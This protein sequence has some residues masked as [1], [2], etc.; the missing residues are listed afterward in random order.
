[1]TDTFYHKETGFFYLNPTTEKVVDKQS[2]RPV[3][4]IECKGV[5]IQGQ[6]IE[7][8]WDNDN[9]S[10]CLDSFPSHLSKEQNRPA[11]ASPLRNQWIS[12]PP[13]MQEEQVEKR[14]KYNTLTTE[15]YSKPL[16]S[17]PEKNAVIMGDAFPYYNDDRMAMMDQK[18]D[19]RIQHISPLT[20]ASFL[21]DESDILSRSSSIRSGP[22]KK[23]SRVS[24]V[25]THHKMYNLGPAAE[26]S[27]I[28]VE[29]STLE[30]W[31]VGK[32]PAATTT[33]TTEDRHSPI[34]VSR[35]EPPHRERSNSSTASFDSGEFYTPPRSVNSARSYYSVAVPE[36][37]YY[38]N[39]V[40]EKPRTY[41]QHFQ[42]HF[43]MN[44]RK[45]SDGPK[46]SKGLFSKL[47]KNIKH[48]FTN[49]S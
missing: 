24:S 20:N 9:F 36:K 42:P 46:F 34:L 13:D 41:S 37:H 7:F 15:Y 32:S 33:T 4:K 30:N 27:Q 22:I 10:L 17:K 6:V 8:P 44:R 5:C 21:D 43:S 25:A 19:T 47:V 49:K 2:S 40:Q 14:L 16:P 23:V 38:A 1:M 28:S 3:S 45:K 29:S 39:S 35:P 31:R 48:H 11:N 18:S 12:D 26:E